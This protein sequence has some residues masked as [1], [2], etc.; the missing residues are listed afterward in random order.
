MFR[1]LCLTTAGVAAAALLWWGAGPL[2][3][4]PEVVQ[5]VLT[6]DAHYGL[7]RPRFRGETN[8]DARVVNQALVAQLNALPTVAFPKDGGVR[9][10]ER[11]GAL[12]FVAETGD[13]VNRQETSG[14]A[15]IQPATIS[16]NQFAADYLEGVSTRDAE[17][18]PTPV[19]VIPGNHEA[20][21]AVGFH[22]PMRPLTD[23]TPIV[24]IYNRMMAPLVPL[25]TQTFDYRRDRVAFSRTIHGLHLVFV[26]VWPDSAQR[27]WIERDL[28]GAAAS[29]PVFLFTHDPPEAESKHFINPNGAHDVNA[30]DQFENLL[31]DTFADGSSITDPAVAEQRALEQFFRQHRNVAAYFHGNSNWNEFYAWTGPDHTIALPVFRVDSPMKGAVSAGDET[32]LSFQ[33]A[34]VDVAQRRMTVRECLWNTVPSTGH[35]PIAWGTTTTVSIAAPRA[36]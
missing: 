31:A 4:A 34:T 24:E 12:D 11:V 3:A 30:T 7:T 25:T 20:S 27:A 15:P 16:W 2:Q 21:N 9:A 13:T 36:R 26:A 8:V 23:A 6:S 35:Q 32:R 22:R 19:F 1:G 28:A 33:V 18:H 29:A 5:F 14:P 10:G 17:G